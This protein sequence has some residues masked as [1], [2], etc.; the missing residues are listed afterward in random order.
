MLVNY[1]LVEYIRYKDMLAMDMRVLVIGQNPCH[2]MLAAVRGGVEHSSSLAF[3][4]E[5]GVQ[6]EDLCL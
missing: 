6:L 4:S 3:D 5:S 2:D 1:I